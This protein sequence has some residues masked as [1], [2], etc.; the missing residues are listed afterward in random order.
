M[1][2]GGRLAGRWRAAPLPAVL[3]DLCRPRRPSTPSLGVAIAGRDPAYPSATR[4][5][6]NLKNT[7][8]VSTLDLE[9]NSTGTDFRSGLNIKALAHNGLFDGCQV[10]L[11]RAFMPSYGDTSLGLVTLFQGPVGPVQVAARGVKVTVKG[12]NVKLHQ[13]MPRNRF[14]LGCIHALYDQGCTMARGDFTTANTVG[15]GS[16]ASVIYWGSGTPATPA[17]YGLG[18]ITFTSGVAEGQRRSL[19][20]SGPTA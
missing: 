2:A 3:P 4:S 9:L 8:E 6:W 5:R 14:E 10:T 12:G 15:A 20:G 1:L 18:Y 11:Q 17:Q 19:S 7:I 13:F 16:T